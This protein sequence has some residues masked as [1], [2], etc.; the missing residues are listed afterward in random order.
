MPIWLAPPALRAVL[1]RVT[2][3]AQRHQVGSVKRDVRIVDVFSRQMDPM[4]HMNG[5]FDQAFAHT[6]LAQ[7]SVLL[8]N[9]I[10]G[11]PPGLRSVE[12]LDFFIMMHSRTLLAVIGVRPLSREELHGWPH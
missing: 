6:D 5:R 11:F 8:Q 9:S 1:I 12:A 3:L 10:P 4:M 7:A 2:S